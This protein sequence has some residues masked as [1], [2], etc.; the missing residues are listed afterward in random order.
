MESNQINVMIVGAEKSGTTSLKNYINE[1]SQVLGHSATEFT[2]FVN[3]KNE[4]DEDYNVVF[5]KYFNLDRLKDHDIVAAK[6]ASVHSNE[7]AIERIFKHNPECKLIYCVR[8]PVDRAYSEFTY[9][10][11]HNRMTDKTFEEIKFILEAGEKRN[12]FYKNYIGH[13]LYHLHLKNM[14]K[15]FPK[16]N[17]KVVLL[18]ELKSNP[19]KV[20][21]DV[22][23]F[24]NVNKNEIIN[25]N[26]VHNKTSVPKSKSLAKFIHFLRS[27]KNVNQF[28]HKIIPFKVYKKMGFALVNLN[29]SGKKFTN[30]DD[31]VKLYL[32]TYF[33]SHNKK[34]GEMT[35]LD[36][37]IW[38]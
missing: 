3:K 15:Y 25:T 5:N 6:N 32:K 18:E 4:Y 26:K 10:K 20:M 17:I 27:N 12:R 21:A 24:M 9:D 14:L 36:L 35:S 28:L 23:A 13:S 37:S 11:S 29:G 33:D 16:E 38:K 2:Y 1:H 8:N 31:K 7:T 22:F 19:D 34:F 30:I